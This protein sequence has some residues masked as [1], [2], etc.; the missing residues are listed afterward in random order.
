MSGLSPQQQPTGDDRASP[1][2]PANA[3]RRASAE[4]R[5]AGHRSASLQRKI[6]RGLV[7]GLPLLWLALFFLVPFAVTLK[8][9]FSSP[10]TAQPPYLPVL[11]W[12]GGLE[13]WR[14]FFEALQDLQG[15]RDS[16][17]YANGS[18]V[19][20]RDRLSRIKEGA[21]IM[22]LRIFRLSS[23]PASVAP[24]RSS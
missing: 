14:E 23:S 5:E 11:E 19:G 18:A 22:P 17:T 10:A 2:D 3:G 8:I 7:R 13:G 9:S 20:L 4:R 21:A 6:G 15:L 24:G 12:D 1:V 16:V